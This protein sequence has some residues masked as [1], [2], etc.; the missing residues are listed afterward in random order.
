MGEDRQ[1]WLIAVVILALSVIVVAYLLFFTP[2]ESDIPTPT[3]GTVVS[4]AYF[5]A[6]IPYS[7]D[8]DSVRNALPGEFEPDLNRSNQD[9]EGKQD[10]SRT[11]LEMP[12][13][14]RRIT[15]DPENSDCPEA[16]VRTVEVT[17]AVELADVLEAAR[18]GDRILL[19]PRRS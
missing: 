3:S 10:T 7:A 9:E 11:L 2:T 6:Q 17:S 8:I 12:E 14:M 1:R 15:P 19:A 4:L 13:W 5:S 18:P 16:A